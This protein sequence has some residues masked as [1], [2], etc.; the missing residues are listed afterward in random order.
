MTANVKGQSY[1][2]FEAP[3]KTPFNLDEN[4]IFYRQEGNQGGIKMNWI[5]YIPDV[6][7]RRVLV[8]YEGG[9][10]VTLTG[11]DAF[12]FLRIVRDKNVHAFV[13]QDS[14]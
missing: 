12:K 11:V 9:R 4:R 2:S 10:T 3:E 1:M 13:P 7:Q 8:V 5:E 6:S 14:N